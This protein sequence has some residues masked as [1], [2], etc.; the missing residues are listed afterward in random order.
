MSTSKNNSYLQPPLPNPIRPKFARMSNNGKTSLKINNGQT[1]LKIDNLPTDVDYDNDLLV[2]KTI[3]LLIKLFNDENDTFIEEIKKIYIPGIITNEELFNEAIKNILKD[4]PEIPTGG[5]K[6]TKTKT[7]KG[8]AAGTKTEQYLHILIPA[9][10]IISSLV[11]Y[12]NGIV[13]PY[14][15]NKFKFYMFGR[16]LYGQM[17]IDFCRVYYAASKQIDLILNQFKTIQTETKSIEELFKNVYATSTSFGKIIAGFYGFLYVYFNIIKKTAFF[18]ENPGTVIKGI[19]PF[20]KNFTTQD[21]P[22]NLT[23]AKAAA[24]ISVE[25]STKANDP[26]PLENLEE[27]EETMG[28]GKYKHKTTKTKAKPTKPKA[29]PSKTKKPTKTKVYKAKTI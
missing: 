5:S 24:D 8:G 20:P 22:S 9:I 23:E 1:S 11:L 4:L 25:V 14:V 26:D 3:E 28:G 19:L 13:D 7:K 12:A 15:C 16:L 17:Q 18:L 10:L 21:M 27:D 29:K 2:N 6:K